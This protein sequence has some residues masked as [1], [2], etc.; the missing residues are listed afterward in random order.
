[1]A[2]VVVG[3]RKVVEPGI[4]A[5]ELGA[6]ARGAGRGVLQIAPV[7]IIGAGAAGL[8]AAIA[9]AEGPV[10]V[11]VLEGTADGGRKILISGGGRCNILPAAIQPER[12][13][14][15]SP[16]AML[17]GLLRS[18]PL[19]DMRRFFE[20]DLSLPLAFEADTGKWF[21]ASHRA[22]DVRDALVRAAQARGVEFR[23]NARVIRVE[24][25]GARWHLGTA[26]GGIE[27]SRVIV[28]DR[29]ALRGARHQA[30]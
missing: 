9:A 1:M 14:T 3:D 29:R 21:P 7:V 25:T 11:T 4:A 12:L 20:H 28:A 15:D 5:L 8:V 30:I 16:P 19:A 26:A 2:V 23:W 27:A 18:W 22:R 13:V 10:P 6:A 24:P 17:R